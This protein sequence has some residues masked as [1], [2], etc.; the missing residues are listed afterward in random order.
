MKFENN[1]D[2]TRSFF[3]SSEGV[4]GT[5]S[6]EILDKTL[7]LT[8]DPELVKIC[9]QQNIVLPCMEFLQTDNVETICREGLLFKMKTMDHLKLDTGIIA[10]N[11]HLECLKYAHEQG[12]D[13]DICYAALGGHL[14][15]VIY[16]HQVTKDQ[17][18]EVWY[19]D[20]AYKGHPYAKWYAA[21]NGHLEILKYL[22]EQGYPWHFFCMTDA[23]FRGHLDC[24]KYARDHGC[25]WHPELIGWAA[26]GGHLEILKY[27]H[28]HGCP[29]DEN[30][31]LE[32][33]IENL[34]CLKYLLEQG[35]SWKKTADSSPTSKEMWV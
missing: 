11:G 7:R 30:L 10:K 33:E 14:D 1:M 18:V 5:L 8:G 15:C 28:E 12:C 13:I 32:V 16:I 31:V 35:Y 4:T 24:L 26:S 3:N 9:N 23:A 20:H 21:K 22:H 19:G 17:L 27:L 25:G 6:P 2:F 29:R 34:D